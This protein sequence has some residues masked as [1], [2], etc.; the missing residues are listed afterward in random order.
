MNTE[1]KEAFK[2]V[3]HGFVFVIGVLGIFI[4]LIIVMNGVANWLEMQPTPEDK[5]FEVVDTYKGCNVVQ[6]TPTN[7]ARYSYFLHCSK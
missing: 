2:E 4:L 1:D 5:K 3:I 6:Y 7:S